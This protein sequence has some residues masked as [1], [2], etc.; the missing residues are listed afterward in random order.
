MC[1]VAGTTGYDY[2]TM[3]MPV[4]VE[5][6]AQ[7]ALDTISA[8]LAEAGF[9][10]SEVVR[11]NYIITHAEYADRVFPVLGKAFGDIRPAATM[12]HRNGFPRLKLRPPRSTVLLRSFT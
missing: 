1:F 7:N 12:I 5:D 8:T 11:A 10:L 2:A 3:T 6:Q 9:S 4:A